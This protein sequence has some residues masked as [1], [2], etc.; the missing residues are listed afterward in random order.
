MKK[1][2]VSAAAFAVVA[3]SAVAMAPT[4][5][6]ANSAFARQ[7]GQACHACHFQ[8]MPRLNDF[9]RKFRINAFRDTGTQ[10]LIEDEGLSLPASF[11]AGLNMAFG[12][13]NGDYK[14]YMGGVENVAAAEGGGQLG[15]P[16]LGIVHSNTGVAWP[17]EAELVVGGRYGDNFGGVATI[18]LAK[19]HR[20]PAPPAAYATHSGG[21]GL[22]H[23]KLAFVHDTELGP[24]A[25]AGG[26]TESR[27]AAYLFNDPS[28]VFGGQLAGWGH[29]SVA[30][31]LH[32]GGL[33]GVNAGA[34]T[35]LGVYAHLNGMAY[36]AIG[37]V[38]PANVNDGLA[39]NFK[40]SPYVRA[41][42][43]GA[44]AGFDVVAGGWYYANKLGDYNAALLSAALTTTINN[45][46]AT[47]Y[48]LDLQVQGAVNGVS[49]GFYL[50]WQIK[51]E[52]WA[53]DDTAGNGTD[54][55]VTGLYPTLTVA[56][57]PFGARLGYDYS[58]TEFKGTALPKEDDKTWV[59]G[60]WYDIAQNVVFNI[61]YSNWDWDNGMAGAS[62]QTAELSSISTFVEYVY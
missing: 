54:R 58:Q 5:A 19:S 1:M 18:D 36:L 14:E 61:E 46:T 24:V 35:A 29:Q 9:G 23:Y 15:L 30:L 11:N 51:G 50:P 39:V 16:D 40:L 2:I 55:D 34:A 22:A 48:G 59:V 3:F 33:G 31:G 44:V 6:L 4:S 8:T 41:A 47:Q 27:G 43:T 28:N 42:F 62:N 26:S 56:S 38:I 57:G 32:G 7:T 12:V 49:I 17:V 13:S 45:R 37:G 60:A 25:I 21:P 52:D 10:G 53:F 20:F